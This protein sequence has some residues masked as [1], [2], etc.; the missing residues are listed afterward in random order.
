MRKISIIGAGAFGFAIANLVSKNNTDKT[1]TLFDINN[2]HISY[3][4]KTGM[5]P[6]FHGD[7]KLPEHVYAT[8]NISDIKGSD[9][10]ILAVPTKFLRV[11]L[12]DIYKNITNDIIFLNLAKGLEKDTNLRVSQ[13]LNE[14]MSDLSYD[15]NICCLSG[16]MIA[17]EVTLENPLCAELACTDRSTAKKVAKLLWSDYLRIE[18]TTD[19]VGVELA[20]A[21]KNVIAVGAGIFDGMGYGESSKSAF[22]SAAARQVRRLAIAL[23]AKRETFG[24]GSQAWFGDLMTTCFGKSRNREL[25][26]LIGKGIKVKDA[27]KAQINNNKSVEGYITTDVVHSLLKKHNIEAPLIHAVHNILYKGEDP[28]DF[29]RKF[30]SAW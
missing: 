8:K 6:L 4:R 15:Y 26:E 21:F 14:E 27:V 17:R 20:G 12:K 28:S 23:G 22:V 30:I 13:I 5:H 3:I 10:I 2:T 1:I 18:T 24:P 29:V 16:G 11:S 19:I 7:V 9:L 25:G